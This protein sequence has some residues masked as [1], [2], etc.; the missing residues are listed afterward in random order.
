MPELPVTERAETLIEEPAGSLEDL[1]NAMDDRDLDAVAANFPTCL[2]A[3]ARLGDR[4]LQQGR[5]IAAY[6]YFRVGYHRGLDRIRGAGWRGK[7]R[8]PWSHEGNRGFLRSLAGLSRAA[9]TIGEAEEA[10]RC[11]SFLAEL[12][13]DSPDLT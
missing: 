6:A 5:P 2:A 7:G 10:Q 12:A 3:W 9:A 4:A 1:M 13:P 8:V 11:R